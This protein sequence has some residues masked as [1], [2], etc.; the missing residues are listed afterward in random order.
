M[1]FRKT[2]VPTSASLELD[3]TAMRRM[4]E[5]ATDR[6]V[7][8]IAS[9]GDQ[10]T[11]ANV[12]GKR[13]AR[14]LREPLPER[15]VSF[16]RLIRLLFGR[17]I[18]MSLN[19][20]SPGYMAYI[21]G[22][23]IFHA[24]VADFIAA[25]TN[26]YVGIWQAAPGL[27]QIEA[28]AVAWCRAMI[29]MPESAFGLLT[30]GGSISNLIATVTARH[31]MLGPEFSDGVAYVSDQVHHSAL[32]ALAIAGVRHVRV[33]PADACF[34][35]DLK[36]VSRALAEDRSHGREPFLIVATAGTTNTGAI[37][38]LDDIADLAAKESLFFHVDG[39]Y[40]G[41]F[42]LTER[43]RAALS[44]IARA[45]TVTLDPH[46]SLFLPYGTGCLLAKDPGALRRAHAMS[47][48]YLPPSETDPELVDFADLGP[49]LS[50][51]ARG[52]RLWLPLK[53]HGAS[54]FRAA[55]DEKLDL[56]RAAAAR[57]S[58][59]PDVEMV[60]EP[61]LSLFA[62]RLAPRAMP[63]DEADALT[64]KVLA[65]VNARRRVFLTGAVVRERFVIRVCVL[66]FRTHADRI[67]MLLSDLAE[68]IEAARAR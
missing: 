49:E 41:F 35:L 48:T 68:A 26:R 21:P 12:G 57:I 24:A 20:A 3:A 64:R 1:A 4:V 59:L 6:V 45:D 39:A 31:E 9:L 25:A 19:T 54:V 32:K 47:A 29:G 14:A 23:G 27:V 18:P 36:A 22:G 5:I 52:L 58:S 62:F 28:N 40:G 33:L 56:A 38:P 34:R 44:G 42:A 51:E 67:E 65:G 17:V 43:G 63:A 16:D 55:L 61:E 11:H 37:D 66:S 8:H 7:K 15:G 30:T 50:R 2:R 10:P 13:L 60:A 53:M 46:K